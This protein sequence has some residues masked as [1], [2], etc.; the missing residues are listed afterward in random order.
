[1]CRVCSFRGPGPADQADLV[2]HGLNSSVLSVK[3][4]HSGGLKIVRAGFA[5]KN[6]G[7]GG[8]FGG[9]RPIFFKFCLS[10]KTKR[11]RRILFVLSV[12]RVALKR[13]RPSDGRY[14]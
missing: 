8:H 1:V 12:K 14:S 11:P 6:D 7:L 2:Q 13:A 3:M 5:R 9:N 4:P 10:S